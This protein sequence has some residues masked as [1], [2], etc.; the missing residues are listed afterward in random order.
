MKRTLLILAVFLSVLTQGYSY[1]SLIVFGDSLSDYGNAGI[2]TSRPTTTPPSNIIGPWGKNLANRLGLPHEK[3]GPVGGT[4]TGTNY[5]R[6]GATSATISAQV[7][8]YLRTS[9]NGSTTAL[10]VFQGGGNDLPNPGTANGSTPALGT[11]AANRIKNYIAQ[12][13][14]AGGGS[15]KT[16]VWFSM[17]AVNRT[18]E[19][20]GASDNALIVSFI[21]NYNSA[22]SS[23]LAALRTQFP[24]STFIGADLY[25]LHNS[26]LDNPSQYNITNTTQ[27]CKNTAANPDV[28]VYWDTLHPTSR[29]HEIL[30]EE[31]ERVITGQ[32]S[33][34]ENLA[35]VPGNGQV[36][37]SWSAANGASSY[38]VKRGA[39]S[40]DPSPVVLNPGSATAYTDS[41]LTNGS[42]YY[43]RV[44]SVN[45][46]GTSGDSDEVSVVPNPP[47]SGSWT[48][49]DVGTV[50]AAGSFSFNS[51]TGVF[52]VN[53]SGSDIFGTADE[54]HLVRRTTVL[55]GDGT[56]TARVSSLQNTHTWAK[57]GVMI[58]ETTAA[59]S[60]HAM[61]AVTSGQGVTFIRRSGTGG[62][63]ASI[64]VAGVT[65]PEWVRLTRSGSS[66]TSYYSSNGTDWIQIGTA[67]TISMGAAVEV[68]L[69]VSA[70]N[71][72]NLCQAVFDN[73]TVVG[74]TPATPTVSVAA[75]DGSAAEGGGNN[76]TFTFTRDTTA[77]SLT[78][79]YSISGTATL[80]SDYTLS[81]AGTSVTIPSGQ[82]SVTVAVAP[83]DDSIEESDE[84]VTATLVASGNYQI[85]TGTATVGIADND[86]ELW[87]SGDIGAVGQAGSSS[88]EP[89][90]GVFTVQGSGADIWGAADAFHFARRSV[91]LTG[92]GTITARVSS[93]QNTNR[94]AKAG[95]MLR[96]TTA[97]GSMNAMTVVSA[98]QGVSFSRRAATGGN[99]A[100]TTVEEVSAPQWVRLVRSGNSFT[101]YYSSDGTAW[102]QIGTAQTISMGATVEVGLCVTSHNNAALCQAVFDHVTIQ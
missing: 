1:N 6:G 18:P 63:S 77:G 99:S 3:S 59:G 36:S 46:A 21:N 100:S 81:P 98:T 35:A 56:I 43:Y 29:V 38:R 83:V 82:S 33:V 86:T 22:W 49:L 40:N 32:P 70:H 53:G 57:V 10:Y 79:N 85:G 66:F 4:P 88:V 45:S 101:S 93:V 39:S 14:A 55:S 62:G 26:I 48:G 61:T 72:G 76:G 69:A 37:L 5:S 73:V 80:A 52:T 31:V 75:T 96:S 74:G 97:A 24:N 60:R 17:F 102:T 71:D 41:G 50:L 89:S 95:V 94:W 7:N 91:G 27:P 64:T 20:A 28:Y 30:A 25:T 42:T 9:A 12:V 16:F 34:P 13:A 51:G 87:T 19:R 44:Y 92:D 84:T 68:G 2:F 65:A 90:T 8:D 23:G 78:V 15:P 11:T 54:F 67:Q 47:V 58:R